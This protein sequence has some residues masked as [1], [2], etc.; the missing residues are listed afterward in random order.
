VTATAT[1]QTRE[2]IIRILRLQ[3]PVLALAS[4]DR[5]NLYFEVRRVADERARFEAL[6]ASLKGLEG[7]AIVY[8]PTRNRTDG[9]AKV[10]RQR[11]F[12]AAPYHAGLPGAARRTLLKRFQRGEIAIMVATSA[13]GMGIDKADVRLVAHLGV[14]LRPE[15]YYQE[16]GRAGR[17][18]KPA[19][20]VLIWAPYDLGLA[21]LFARGGERK[22]IPSTSP[23]QRG[24]VTANEALQQAFHAMRRYVE[25]RE[26]RRK[27]LLE[28]LG[29]RIYRCSGC[30]RCAPENSGFPSPAAK[31]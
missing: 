8:L 14:P 6:V 26:C 12:N 18:G 5:P 21:S 27:L 2:D 31:S 4:F 9:I 15:S 7:S 24:S 25:G 28:Y 11:G 30:D 23:A 1:P 17:D 20:C 29:E 16:A 19:R 22:K 3:R 13:F 10:L